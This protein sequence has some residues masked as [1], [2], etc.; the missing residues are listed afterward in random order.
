MGGSYLIRNFNI[1]AA[2]LKTTNIILASS[3]AK[4]PSLIPATFP[5][6]TVLHFCIPRNLYIHTI[7]SHD[8]AAWLKFR[9]YAC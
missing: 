4:P 8:A 6:Y 9:K 7:K 2:K 5:R 3:G 1:S